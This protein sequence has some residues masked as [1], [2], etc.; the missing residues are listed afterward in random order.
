MDPY[1]RDGRRMTRRIVNVSDTHLVRARTYLLQKYGE[2]VEI[3]QIP[4]GD[5]WALYF[6]LPPSAPH[7]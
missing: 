7:A 1:T 6:A 5:R 2:H 3:V 4:D